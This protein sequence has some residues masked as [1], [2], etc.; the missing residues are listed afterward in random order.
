MRQYFTSFLILLFSLPCFAQVQL[1]PSIGLVA[2]P[3]DADSICPIQTFTGNY[4]NVGIAEG[5][6][7]P[8]F[9]LYTV[10]GDSL[11]IASEL[12][13]GKHIL[14]VTGAYT[15]PVF[16]GK[17]SKIHQVA[18]TYSDSIS[19]F[20]V[21]V[22]EA[23]PAIDISPYSGQVWTTS[24]NQ[25][26]GILYPQPKTYLE[27]KNVV[28]D[29]VSAM[30]ITVPVYIDG[31]CNAYWNTFGPAPNNSYLIRRDG[32]VFS[33]QGWFDKAP[34][35]ISTDIDSLL[36][37]GG[38]GGNP[39]NGIFTFRLD[40]DTL[41]YDLPGTTI[42]I[43]GML[44]NNSSADVELDIIRMNNNL[45]MGWQSALCTDICLPPWADSSYVYL[46][47]GDSI[48]FNFYFYTDTTPSTGNARIGFSNRNVTNNRFV[49]RFYA[50]TT[51][52]VGIWD[53]GPVLDNIM[54]VMPNPAFEKV[55][56]L[57]PITWS[58]SLV[59][60]AV[61]SLE[62]KSILRKTLTLADAEIELDIHA[63]A[64]GFYTA[65]VSQ[66]NGQRLVSKI[67]KQ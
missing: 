23:H 21:Y 25:S 19:V 58:N 35:N 63:I 42:T 62:G 46:Y 4:N 24:Q 48:P 45:P 67:V 29:M 59:E 54:I 8:H 61:F 55:Q 66:R 12:N 31:P 37:I 10:N 50:N 17:V 38:G 36:G 53:G 6:T 18:S 39:L 14:L 34:D 49:R 44:K 33:Y 43:K 3:A 27:R 16:R 11:D 5:D 1:K 65:I 56:L 9:K 15:C 2:M 30:S 64:P 40:T 26:S 20:I 28:S 52:M 41:L 51:S 60:L 7:I 13:K 22:V 57:L 47:P 32:V